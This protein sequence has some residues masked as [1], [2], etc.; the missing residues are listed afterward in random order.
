[1]LPIPAL[2]FALIALPRP[3]LV[4]GADCALVVSPDVVTAAIFSG[5]PAPVDANCDGALSAADVSAAIRSLATPHTPPA[6]SP[7]P[8]PSASATRT[9]SPLPAGSYTPTPTLRSCPTAGARLVVDVANQT[10]VAAISVVLTGERLDRECEP[11]PL[12]VSYQVTCSGA[13]LGTCGSITGLAPGSWRHSIAVVSPST[14]QVQHQRSLLLA[15]SDPNLIAFTA[16]ATVL[17]VRSTQNTGTGSLRSQIGS[18][19]T[20]PKPLL[21]QF[22]PAVFPAGTPTAIQLAFQLPELAT[23]DVTIDGT[24][25]I[26]AVGNRIIDA[27]A[28]PIPALVITGARNHILGLRLRNAGSGNRDVLSIS[29]PGADG[30]VVE[31][32]IIDTAASADAVGIDQQAGKDFGATVNLVRDCEVFGA[33]D[34]GIK[35]TTQAYARIE[36]CWVHDNANGGIQATLGGNVQAWRNLVERNFGS[37]AQ[38]GLSVNARDD[39]APPTETSA[40]E[41]WGNISRAN[42]AN[43]LAVRAGSMAHIHDDYLASNGTSGLRIFNDVGGPATAVVE[44]ITAACNDADGAAVANTSIADLGG[45]T[46]GSSGNNAFTQNNLPGGAAN[47]RNA[48]GALLNATNNQWEHCGPNTTCDYA[49]IAAYDLSDHGAMTDFEPAQAHRSQQPPVVSGALPT[50]GEQGELLRIFGTGF[51][52][53]DGHSAQP[54]CADVATRNRCVPLRGNCVRIN[55]VPAPVEAVTPTMLVV[56]WP[57]TCLEPIPLLVQIDQGA[58]S[59]SS[60]PVTVCTNQPPTVHPPAIR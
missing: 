54:N 6:Q 1:M 37:T 42:G 50:K 18:A 9:A 24:D 35:V 60:V 58:T 26:G 13:A 43:G 34:K 38:N 17:T 59:T 44:G 5:G 41:T 14:G 46:L 7:T 10:G 27:G 22:D 31:R 29:G 53:I 28:L 3:G 33:A 20:V 30:N 4:I 15:G 36:D 49:K 11:G 55:G 45:G 32:S 57:F 23:D 19:A 12:A 51:N 47:L 56:R 48:T 39:N 16:F 21:I 8:T 40:M 25:P 2:I 52:V